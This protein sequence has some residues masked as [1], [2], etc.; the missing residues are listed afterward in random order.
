MTGRATARRA[1]GR[2]RPLACSSCGGTDVRRRWRGGFSRW[3]LAWVSLIA[4]G[5]LPLN[6]SSAPLP[7]RLTP[8]VVLGLGVAVIGAAGV[9]LHIGERDASHYSYQ[10]RQCWNEWPAQ[11]R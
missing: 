10:C 3:T 7:E 8:M 2:G 6:L 9:M 4:L 11:P 5:L 1:A